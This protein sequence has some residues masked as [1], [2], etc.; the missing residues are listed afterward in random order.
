MNKSPRTNDLSKVPVELYDDGVYY[1]MCFTITAPPETLKTVMTLFDKFYEL[2]GG[3]PTSQEAVEDGMFI[4]LS[5]ILKHMIDNED[6]D[7]QLLGYSIDSE[8]RLQVLVFCRGNA[9]IPFRDAFL[10]SFPTIE[11]I[12]VMG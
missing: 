9:I 4:P 7:G 2:I 11:F 12:E 5:L 10:N 1:G 6:Y 8:G 3:D